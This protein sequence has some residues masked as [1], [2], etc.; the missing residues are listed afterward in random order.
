VVDSISN[1]LPIQVVGTISGTTASGLPTSISSLA[2][3]QHVVII[4]EDPL[5]VSLRGDSILTAAT[6]TFTESLTVSGIPVVLTDQ[7]GITAV[8]EDLT[9]ELGGDLDALDKNISNVKLLT[10]SSGT[11]SESLTIS[12]TPVPLAAGGLQNIVEDATP[13]LGGDLDAL[14][15]DIVNVGELTAVSG[16]FSDTVSGTT[17][18][19]VTGTITE[20]LTVGSGST[21]L[22]PDEIRT[23]RYI[24]I[25]PGS[26]SAPSITFVGSEGQTNIGIY[27]SGSE[28]I[29]ITH[30]STET[31]R[32][33]SGALQ[34]LNSAL[35]SLTGNLS[36]SSG[37]TIGGNAKWRFTNISSNGKIEFLDDGGN[38]RWDF[39]DQKLQA[40]FNTNYILSGYGAGTEPSYTFMGDGHKTGMFLDN[41]GTPSVLGFSTENSGGF[42]ETMVLLSGSVGMGV[43]GEITATSGIFTTGLNLPTFSSD[44]AVADGDVW[45]NTT[46]S[47]IRWQVDGTKF[48]IQGTPV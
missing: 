9:P 48:E 44:P 46:T 1:I 34:L 18:L 38:A 17:L 3:I 36:V 39:D 13:E 43:N 20:G 12:G 19:A 24:I 2:N 35:L 47:G 14:N 42:R 31:V 23:D 29:G 8:V 26:V 5:E 40:N 16:T 28:D 41:S 32:F 10:A 37:K 33:S 22:F 45:I 11:F 7:V 30:G 25:D 27:R 6:G 21:Y 4:N 15:N